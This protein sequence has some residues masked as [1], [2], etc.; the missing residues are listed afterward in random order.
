MYQMLYIKDYL[1]LPE[2]VPPEVIYIV[3]TNGQQWLAVLT[4]PC[5]CKRK[6]PL[7]LLGDEKPYWEFDDEFGANISPSVIVEGCNIEFTLKQGVVKIL[8]R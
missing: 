5:G 2:V 3:S 1:E 7:N 6:L 4:C 8:D